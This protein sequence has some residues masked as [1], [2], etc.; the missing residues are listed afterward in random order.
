MGEKADSGN[1]GKRD[2]ESA[3]TTKARELYERGLRARGEVARRSKDG[4]LPPG[5]T[6]E[7]VDGKPVRARFSA[8]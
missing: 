3:K 1:R 8:F 2:K 7:L 5:A 4:K 6:H